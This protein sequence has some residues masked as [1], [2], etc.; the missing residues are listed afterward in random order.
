MRGLTRRSKVWLLF[1][2]S[3]PINLLR[4]VLGIA[5]AC[6]S[7]ATLRASYDANRLIEC[8]AENVESRADMLRALLV[9]ELYRQLSEMITK[10][11]FGKK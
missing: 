1:G 10:S 6:L 9:A 3:I 7:D 2:D 4:L 8:H 11:L 5:Y